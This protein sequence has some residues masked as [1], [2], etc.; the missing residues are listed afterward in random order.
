MTIGIYEMTPKSQLQYK[1]CS[2]GK[3][4]HLV[5]TGSWTILQPFYR[6]G[7]L[8]LGGFVFRVSATFSGFWV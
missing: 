6:L 5:F 2:L 3:L 8:R 7:K 4:A 1:K